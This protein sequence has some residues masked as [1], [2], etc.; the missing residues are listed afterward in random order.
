MVQ[1]GSKAREGSDRTGSVYHRVSRLAHASMNSRDLP[2]LQVIQFCVRGMEIS[3]RVSETLLQDPERSVLGKD[4]Q[5]QARVEVFLF[6]LFPVLHL[7]VK[8]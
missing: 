8:I 5:P 4:T 6:L 2:S 1:P 7:V 3:K